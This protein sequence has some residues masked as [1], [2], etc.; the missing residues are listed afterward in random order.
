M[1]RAKDLVKFA[2]MVGLFD[3]LFDAAIGHAFIW[4][5]DPYWTY[6][7]T[8]TFL[9][10]TVFTIG[11]AIAGIGKKQGAIISLVHTI[12]LT[13]YYWTF[14][15]VGL[16]KEVMWLDVHHTWTT[17]VPIHFLVIYLGYLG[18]SWVWTNTRN[19]MEIDTKAAV[20]RSLIAAVISVVVLCLLS[21]LVLGQFVGITWCLTRIL[22]LFPFIFLWLAYMPDT[23]NLNLFGVFVISLALA[24]YSHYLSPLGL[25]GTWR[26]FDTTNPVTNPYWLNYSELWFRQFPVYFAVLFG[27]FWL[28]RKKDLSGK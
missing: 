25:P 15:P 4:K 16:P 22:V 5:N 21:S 18:A 10:V 17:G 6:W 24:S 27:T 7:I 13:V 11:T 3:I 20:W 9:I 23:G 14:S 19:Q 8:K 2:L 12:V 26:L 1:L 28:L